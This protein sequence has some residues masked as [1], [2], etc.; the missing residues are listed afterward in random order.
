MA[1]NKKKKVEVE[2][3]AE[4]IDCPVVKEVFSPAI[5][6]VKISTQLDHTKADLQAIAPGFREIDIAVDDAIIA[7]NRAYS[8]AIFIE[9]AQEDLAK[10]KR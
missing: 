3:K 5:D 8:L 7:I 4:V 9:R 10:K 6:M 1:S 2:I